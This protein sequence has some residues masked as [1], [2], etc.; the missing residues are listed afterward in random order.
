MRTIILLIPLLVQVMAS[1]QGLTP[2]LRLGAT[3]GSMDGIA[4]TIIRDEW[5]PDGS[6]ATSDRFRLRA[7]IGA[8]LDIQP[9][10][11][12]W[13]RLEVSVDYEHAWGPSKKDPSDL[14]GAGNHDFEYMDW[15][16]GNTANTADSLRYRLWFNYSYVDIG[17]VTN[18][19]FIGNDAFRLGPCIGFN[20]GFNVT[21]KS[22]SYRSNHPELGPDLQIQENLSNVLRGKTAAW[23]I[24]GVGAQVG[25]VD[26]FARYRLGL[27]D[28]V[29]TEA[30]SYNF[31][32]NKNSAQVSWLFG[33]GCRF[34]KPDSPIKKAR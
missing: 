15:F 27:N 10:N 18:L 31:I 34:K 30:N 23:L 3:Y 7:L 19:M 8:Y 29:V 22:L 21:P 32:D 6:Y 12:E 9:T 28:L 5:Y 17:V 1:A 13:L 11:V 16:N 25:R 33:V 14:D 26:L 2:G 24:G 20:V 4:K